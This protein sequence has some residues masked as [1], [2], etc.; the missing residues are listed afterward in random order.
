M[1]V[2]LLTKGMSAPMPTSVLCLTP[3]VPVKLP[4]K[5]H[6]SQPPASPTAFHTAW[7]S[8]S[9]KQFT[10]DY[11]PNTVHALCVCGF[12]KVLSPQK[13]FSPQIRKLPHLRKAPQI[14]KKSKSANFR[15][16]DM[17]N[18]QYLRTAHL[19]CLTQCISSPPYQM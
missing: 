7:Q 16:C 15:I 8:H 2:P 9:I 13:I 10:P 12:V 14:F 19:C 11:L 5:L 6:A 4:N 1:P 17:R 3:C 18:L